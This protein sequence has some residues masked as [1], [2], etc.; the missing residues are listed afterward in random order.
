[1]SDFPTCKGKCWI[2]PHFSRSGVGKY[3]LLFLRRELGRK[4]GREGA[5]PRRDEEKA[6]SRVLTEQIIAPT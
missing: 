4:H 1:M 3:N 2:F 5:P 6:Q